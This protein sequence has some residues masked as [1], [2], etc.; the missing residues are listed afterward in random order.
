MNCKKMISYHNI[1]VF[2]KS[3][4]SNPASRNGHDIINI[5]SHIPIMCISNISL[6]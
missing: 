2:G 4:D 3:K 5:F 1:T 6:D